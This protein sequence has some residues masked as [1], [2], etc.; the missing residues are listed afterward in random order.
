MGPPSWHTGQD[1]LAN[2]TS[3]SLGDPCASRFTPSMVFGFGGRPGRLRPVPTYS[4]FDAWLIRRA[5]P[6]GSALADWLVLSDRAIYVEMR[7]WRIHDVSM[8][9]AYRPCSAATLFRRLMSLVTAVSDRTER[10]CS[11]QSS[12]QPW[13]SS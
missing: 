1:S 8:M 3:R 11:R 7:Y 2:S 10:I 5:G 6:E 4:F 12:L 9:T 13:R